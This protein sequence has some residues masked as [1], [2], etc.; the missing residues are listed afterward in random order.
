MEEEEEEEEEE[1]VCILMAQD[2]SSLPH[3]ND[4][5]GSMAVKGFTLN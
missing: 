4:L 5:T 1:E 3:K 2:K